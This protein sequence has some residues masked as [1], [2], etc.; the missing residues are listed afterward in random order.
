M[1]KTSDELL[2]VRNKGGQH[3]PGLERVRPH[4][5]AHDVVEATAVGVPRHATTAD[6]TFPRRAEELKA[7]QEEAGVV[8]R[9]HLAHDVLER[10]N[11]RDERRSTIRRYEL[12]CTLGLAIA[13]LR[14]QIS[15]QRLHR[16][17][18]PGDFAISQQS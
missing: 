14:A 5:L 15:V 4:R 1:G 18:Q 10:G 17:S 8:E 7:F 2:F 16:D 12:V 11:S 9:L 3:L 6:A 13:L